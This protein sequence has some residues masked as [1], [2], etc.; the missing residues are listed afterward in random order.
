MEM[1][2]RMLCKGTQQKSLEDRPGLS[3]APSRCTSLHNI[4]YGIFFWNR[5]LEAGGVLVAEKVNIE[6]DLE[7]V[8][9]VIH[10]TPSQAEAG[11]AR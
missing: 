1:P 3:L 6:I 5:A 9:Q 8:Q 4:R 10:P 11:V 7:V 2:Y